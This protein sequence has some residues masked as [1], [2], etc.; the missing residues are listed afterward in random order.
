MAFNELFTAR[1]SKIYISQAAR[2]FSSF[3]QT[4]PL[5]I[6]VNRIIATPDTLATYLK[7]N[8]IQ[9]E[10]VSWYP[11][12]F[13]LHAVD[14]RTLTSLAGYEQG[15][16]YIQNLSSMIPAI[17]IDP[18]QN[19][20]ILDLTAAPGSKTTQLASLMQNSGSIVANDISNNRLY[21]LKANL[22]R[23]G[24]TNTQVKQ[25]A[26]ERFWQNHFEE[27]DK[28]LIDAPCSMESIFLET[29]EKTYV[30]WSIKEIKHLARKQQWMLRSAVSACKPG[31][32]IIYSTCTLSPEENEQVIDWILE[33]DGKKIMLEDIVVPGLELMNGI[34]SFEG[35]QYNP[36]V[37]K[38]KR[39]V[40][41]P[42]MEGFFIA[43][44]RKLT[45]W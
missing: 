6:R 10:P 3:K 42:T 20:H 31:G 40:P 18:Q 1:L 25:G 5:T 2:V 27:F 26:A 15:M 32:T 35:K 24:V 8:N 14:S 37:A 45:Q 16:L 21:K 39:V 33:K 23:Y 19:D 17:V 30:D 4:K 29:D 34:T 41:S 11:D 7:E 36:E 44:I 12:A 22:T 13:V 9:Y 43:K 28:V 38:T